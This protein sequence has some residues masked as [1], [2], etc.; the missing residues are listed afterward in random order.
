[1]HH[2]TE[3]ITLNTPD[4]SC[5]HCV[6]A[7]QTRLGSLDGISRVTASQKTKTVQIAFDSSRLNLARIEEELADEGY[8]VRK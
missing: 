4:I 2:T 6:N 1:M 8:P 3:E 5:A 7:I